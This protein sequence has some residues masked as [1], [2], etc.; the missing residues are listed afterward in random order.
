VARWTVSII[1]AFLVTASLLAGE[2]AVVHIGEKEQPYKRLPKD[3]EQNLIKYYGEEKGKEL[4]AQ[5]VE[6][7]RKNPMH[8][9]ITL[10]NSDQIR[11]ATKVEVQIEFYDRLNRKLGE[12]LTP[13]EIEI[14][15]GDS[16]NVQ[17]DCDDYGE[18]CRA[19]HK[20]WAEVKKNEWKEVKFGA[21]N[22]IAFEWRDTRW[23]LENNWDREKKITVRSFSAGYYKEKGF[24]GRVFPKSGVEPDE[25]R[26][27]RVVKEQIP[28]GVAKDS[29]LYELN[30][31]WPEA[32]PGFIVDNGQ[33]KKAGFFDTGIS[34]LE[35]KGTVAVGEYVRI[36]NASTDKK[37]VEIVLSPVCQ[38]APGHRALLSRLRFVMGPRISDAEAIDQAVRAWFE[39]V[40]IAEV[41]KTCGPNS[42][43]LVRRWDATTT[44]DQIE[45]ELGPAEA[46][47]DVAGGE[48][49]VYGSLRLKFVDGKLAG[50]ERKLR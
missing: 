9:S 6:M 24:D 38:T 16:K 20:V 49:L 5:T 21:A 3:G 35:V 46:R 31:F 10:G 39:P 45:A 15:P 13:L 1:V 36:R 18:P 2:V 28:G 30:V 42:G 14:P 19:S 40:S 4:W 47:S 34:N 17:I 29:T 50:F 11:K 23:Y 48:I 33:R 41:A 8:Y 43:R 12:K 27:Y 7:S 26:F 22:E 32:F 25:N 37:N 44:P